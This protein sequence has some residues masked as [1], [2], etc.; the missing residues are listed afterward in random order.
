PQS[1]RSQRCVAARHR[2]CAVR[3]QL[4]SS[5]LPETPPPAA[6]P[7]EYPHCPSGSTHRKRG[8]PPV[9]AERPAKFPVLCAGP[10]P[11]GTPVRVRTKCR[12]QCPQRLTPSRLPAQPTESSRTFN[13]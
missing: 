9:P 3:Q 1:A 6:P 10:C 5:H 8:C 7:H 2:E 11:A 13:L 12:R 4:Q